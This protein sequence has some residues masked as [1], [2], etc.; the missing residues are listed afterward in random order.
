MQNISTD[1]F[2]IIILCIYV[3]SGIILNVITLIVMAP[4]VI[5]QTYAKYVLS[6]FRLDITHDLK[7]YFK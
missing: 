2:I 4:S 3:P 6:S 1:M 5:R 7:K